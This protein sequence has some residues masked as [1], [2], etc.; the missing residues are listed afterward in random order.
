MAT[1]ARKLPMK[2]LAAIAIQATGVKAGLVYVEAAPR[3]S[4]REPIA[5]PMGKSLF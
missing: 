1:V 2:G 3:S 4:G 5:T